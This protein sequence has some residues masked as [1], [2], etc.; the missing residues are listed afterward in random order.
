[1]N[2]MMK[3]LT[4]TI[5]VFSLALAACS[6]AP[7]AALEVVETRNE[8]ARLLQMGAKSLRE[9]SAG[10]AAGFYGEA[11]R[12][13]TAIDNAEGRVRALDGLGRLPPN[14]GGMEM[15]AAWKLASR[16]AA[17]DGDGFI[18]ALATLLRGELAILRRAEVEY[19]DILKEVLAAA[20]ALTREPK[21][22]SRALRVAGALS[23]ASGDAEGALE[24][25]AQAAQIDKGQR[26]FIEYA[27]DRFLAASVLSKLGRLDEAREAL[28]DALDNDRRAENAPGI[29]ADFHALSQVAAKAGQADEARVWAER[30]LEV[31]RAARLA[32]KVAELEAYLTQLGR[33][34]GNGN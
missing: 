10:A 9:G 24:Y 5:V 14:E 1:M 34:S 30:S 26:A 27:S 8:A 23:K 3:G 15:A 22:R 31:Y 16:I 21:D 11:Y 19:A 13:Y 33:S 28:L 6:S 2:G 20:E 17:Q 18:L 12:L 29:A 32:A 25:F 7:K 4:L